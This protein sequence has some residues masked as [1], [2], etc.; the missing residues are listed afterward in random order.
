MVVATANEARNQ[1]EAHNMINSNIARVAQ[2]HSF[3]QDSNN[4][5]YIFMDKLNGEVK[6]SLIEKTIYRLFQESSNTSR[7][8]T[9]TDLVP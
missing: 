4:R 1:A 6:D 8:S 7:L 2:V 3:F 5:G 9:Q